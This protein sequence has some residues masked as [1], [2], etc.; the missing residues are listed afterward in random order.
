VGGEI[1][2]ILKKWFCGRW[3][4]TSVWVRRATAGTCDAKDMEFIDYYIS[5]QFL[6]ITLE[7]VLLLV[8]TRKTMFWMNI[9]SALARR[10]GLALW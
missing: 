6:S 8:G 9:Q 7:I 2:M 4:E 3:L 1:K 5:W 10:I